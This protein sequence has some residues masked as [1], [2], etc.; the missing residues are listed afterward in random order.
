VKNKN[1]IQ[2]MVRYTNQAV[3]ACLLM[4]TYL[5]SSSYGGGMAVVQAHEE[6]EVHD[7][8]DDHTHEP[9]ESTTTR[10]GNNGNNVQ[11]S[12]S[13]LQATTLPSP[14]S[15][16]SIA[17]MTTHDGQLVIVLTGGCTSPNGNELVMEEWGESFSC[18]NITS[19]VRVS[20]M[21]VSQSIHSLFF[22]CPTLFLLQR[23]THTH[24]SISFF[25]FV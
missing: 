20:F 13:Y 3:A 2:G 4:T 5:S 18:K 10:G 9:E 8:Y 24:L 11:D 6:T 1:Q 12:W 17:K 7:E 15:D 14:M 21:S 25:L 16:V 22:G 19:Q 23:A